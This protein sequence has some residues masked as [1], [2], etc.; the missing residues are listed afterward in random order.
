[1]EFLSKGFFHRTLAANTVKLLTNHGSSSGWQSYS[2]LIQE[3]YF[4]TTFISLNQLYVQQTNVLFKDARAVNSSRKDDKSSPW[5]CLKFIALNPQHE[6]ELG[7][8]RT[9]LINMIIWVPT[10]WLNL[11]HVYLLELYYILC[12]CRNTFYLFTLV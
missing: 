12:I 11:K 4:G 9:F 3:I 1:M 2:I 5:N 7:M 10:N 8:L 6:L